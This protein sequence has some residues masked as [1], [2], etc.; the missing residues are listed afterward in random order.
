MGDK[1]IF[2]AGASSFFGRSFL[3]DEEVRKEKKKYLLHFRNSS[4]A[5]KYIEDGWLVY[6]GELSDFSLIEQYKGRIS[7]VIN[8][9]GSFRGTDEVLVYKNL[10]LTVKLVHIMSA[11]GATDII[12]FSSAAVYGETSE[13]GVL[14]DAKL[15]PTTTY[16]HVKYFSEQYLEHAIA[17]KL[18]HAAVIFRVNNVYGKGCTDG[19]ISHFLRKARAGEEIGVEGK[20]LQIREPLH[21]KDLLL[22]IKLAIK[23][24]PRGLSLFNMSGAEKIQIYEIAALVKEVSA[25]GSSI[26]CTDKPE[27]RPLCLCLNTGKAS[28]ELGWVPVYNLRDGIFEVYKS[29]L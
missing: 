15:A 25:T 27:G 1:L 20:G 9:I 12:H 7:T 29:N 13:E 14:E 24:S 4:F 8:L 2:V 23:K 19:V 3:E 21:I 10:S 16:G 22:A 18:I 11:L 5:K 28:Q 6:I 26:I 17:M